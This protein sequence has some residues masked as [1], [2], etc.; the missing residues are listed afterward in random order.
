MENQEL[1]SQWNIVMIVYG[2]YALGILTG[3]LFALVGVIIAHLKSGQ[4][5]GVIQS[6]LSYQVRTFWYGVIG[7]IIGVLTMIV[8]IGFLI[9]FAVVVWQL[10][11][12]VKGFLR[13]NE[14]SPIDDPNT[15]LF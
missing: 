5:D 6:H 10:I 2:L 14:R 12:I 7:A 1:K 15:L 9:L 4:V 11:R 13:A 8:G 3:G